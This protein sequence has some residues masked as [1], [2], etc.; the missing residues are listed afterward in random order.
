[1]QIC[2]SWKEGHTEVEVKANGGLLCDK[3]RTCLPD[4]TQM[5]IRHPERLPTSIDQAS[6]TATLLTQS[7]PRQTRLM[8]RYVA[9]LGLV[10]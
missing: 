3:K 6:C 9:Q 4:A 5:V 8:W 7:N 10:A 1:M 2:R